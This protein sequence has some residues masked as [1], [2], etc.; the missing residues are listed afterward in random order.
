MSS[1]I[2]S[3]SFLRMARIVKVALP[4]AAGVALC[5]DAGKPLQHVVFE[6]KTKLL[7]AI[8]RLT[9][10]RPGWAALSK[11]KIYGVDGRDL[12]TASLSDERKQPI[13]TLTVLVE[14]DSEKALVATLVKTV[15]ECVE[16]E[17]ALDKELNLMTHEL[18]E[19][20]EELN[21]VYHTED[22]VSFFRQGQEALQNLTQNCLD[23]LDVD[24]AVLILKGKGVEILCKRPEVQ[25]ADSEHVL[26]QLAENAYPWIDENGETVVMNDASDPLE[27]GFL[28]EGPNKYL[29]C[30]IFETS[31]NV[32]GMLATVNSHEKRA[33]ANSD[34][35]LVRVM[36]RK[37]SKI[38]ATNF[39]ALT[40]LMNRNGYEYHLESALKQ[41]QDTEAKISLLHI[42]IDQMQFVNDT[43]GYAAGDVV[44]RSVAAI[45]ESKKRDIDTLC[46]IGGDEFGVLMPE[47]PYDDAAEAAD[48]LCRAIEESTLEHDG[49]THNVTIS[50]GIAVITDAIESV[51]QLIGVAEL[52]CSVA[53]ERGQNRVEAYGPENTGIIRRSAE[54]GFVA[55][56]Q[57]ALVDDQFELFSQ[58]IE[59]LQP[60][61]HKH[62][63]EIL[64]R[65]IDESGDL[66]LP[67]KFISAAERY[68]LMP[69]IDRLVVS[70]ALAALA[71][72]DRDTLLNGTFSINLSG[73]SLGED[74]FLEFVHSEI[75]KSGVPPECICF[76]ITETAAV[77]NIS[78]ASAFMDSLGKINCLF[79][80]DD[81]GAGISSFGYL[82]NLPADLLKIDGAIVKDIVLDEASDAMVIAINEVGHAM[83]LR[84]I[85]EY[86]ENEAIKSRLKEIGV[87][88]AQG[89]VIGEPVKLEE[90]F[91][92]LSDATEAVAS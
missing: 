4:D 57:S 14:R 32:A 7:S 60:G 79:S 87:D 82:K 56:I 41:V 2:A 12:L 20:Y 16:H 83:K 5:D 6:K 26:S 27:F 31:G 50:V 15:A 70:K 72:I 59:P 92:E 25:T 55:Q 71:D 77:E 45:I 63:T 58:V 35:N 66:I 33:F 40:G 29:C 30:P 11:T 64:L 24:M 44:I 48:S 38:I 22:E 76:E 47:L 54:M 18:T 1:L 28:L 73:Q 21:L 90:R 68:H 85:A 62:H 19:R 69:A 8:R 67:D 75:K 10:K 78:K 81:F 13:A 91:R 89:N 39:D 23:Y 61:S 42:N 51:E 49:K 74:D 46:R 43:A 34:R 84:T 65:L 52:A 80:L 17:M 53:K 3:E 86:V 36:A 37:V 88:Y 9:K